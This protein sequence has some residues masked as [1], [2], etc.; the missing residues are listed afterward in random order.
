MSSL[1]CNPSNAMDRSQ[2]ISLLI[3]SFPNLKRKYFIE[4]IFHTS[5]Y[6]KKDSYILTR[7]GKILSYAQVFIKN[8]YCAGKRKKIVGLG[9][10]CTLSDYRKK[11]LASR[12]IQK[13]IE[14]N[15]D[16]P[17]LLFTKIPEYY[18]R[19]DFFV[20]P[21]KLYTFKR[22]DWEFLPLKKIKIRKFSFSKDIESVIRIYKSYFISF[23]GVVDRV[24]SDWRLQML[25]FNEDK[26]FFLVLEEKDRIK[27]YI[28]CKK[29]PG[30]AGD[31][32]LKIVEYADSDGKRQYIMYFITHIFRSGLIS[33]VS[34]H[35]IFFD[36]TILNSY[37]AEEWNDFT[38]MCRYG[39][40]DIFR[41]EF[42]S[43]IAFLE[44]DAF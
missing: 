16:L 12:I 1:V 8:I 10:V 32:S 9:F 43:R 30:I 24:L 36:S 33:Q 40:S 28:R 26:N 3:N 34:G 22:K 27:A 17:L 23:V 44:A 25:Y 41:D 20:L 19:F 29:L 42:K 11:G 6:R 21:R 7:N 2:I 18:Q 37:Q 39:K 14:K 35:S 38:M 5:Q 15:K 4:R 13:I 31:D